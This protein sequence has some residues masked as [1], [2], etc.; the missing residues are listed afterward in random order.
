MRFV[1][2]LLLL[3]FLISEA[4]S[5][6]VPRPDLKSK[7]RL[8]RAFPIQSKDEAELPQFSENSKLL[9][10]K[11][12][13]N[14]VI[15]ELPNLTIKSTITPCSGRKFD[16]SFKLSDTVI[17]T[18]CYIEKG[19]KGEKE[20]ERVETWSVE[21][22]KKLGLS[23]LEENELKI[24]RIKSTKDHS[25]LSE[26]SPD[27]ER[28]AIWRYQKEIVE[29]WDVE[30]ERKI[31]DIEGPV[32]GPLVLGEKNQ[33]RVGVIGVIFSPDGDI[34]AV[35]YEAVYIS[36]SPYSI[37]DIF[38]PSKLNDERVYLWNARTGKKLEHFLVEQGN[39][40][41]PVFT[42]D[43]KYLI[44]G[45]VG[46]AKVWNIRTGDLIYDFGH[47]SIVAVSP[48]GKKLATGEISRVK[49]WDLKNKNLL[50]TA[51]KAEYSVILLRF[52]SDSK[53]LYVL[54][55]IPDAFLSEPQESYI[56]D[57]EKQTLIAKS[58]KDFYLSPDFRY[59]LMRNKV[60]GKRVVELYELI[61]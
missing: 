5:Q 28:L 31:V 30:K 46:G 4:S 60:K 15:F 22:G 45:G 39:N 3:N 36:R 24:H 8:L 14:L 2:L 55:T 47:G 17:L 1:A 12:G 29:L 25:F 19:K 34:L 41:Y 42:P 52:S 10:V 23:K 32:K 11:E 56:F 50:W 20:L 33:K 35:V 18:R 37:F 7:S 43:G 6:K 61:E 27:G 53:K 49:V 21:D 58:S 57:L 13:E 44:T 54:S 51:P 38:L 26:V 9:A 59:F 40:Q 16:F 48:D